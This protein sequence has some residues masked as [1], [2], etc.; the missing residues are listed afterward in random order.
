MCGY[1]IGNKRKNMAMKIKIGSKNVG[2]GSPVF[3]FGSGDFTNLP[4]SS[5]N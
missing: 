4:L 1:K 3:K 2:S 5:A